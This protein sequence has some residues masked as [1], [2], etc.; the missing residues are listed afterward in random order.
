MRLPD[1]DDAIQKGSLPMNRRLKR[2]WLVLLA[3]LMCLGAAA[4]R[5]VQPEP[6]QPEPEKQPADSASVQV[7][8]GQNGR[9]GARAANGRTLIEPTWYYLR[10]MSDTVLIARSSDGKKDCFGLIRSNGEVLV[11]FIYS[12][13]APVSGLQDVWK[14]SFTE[15]GRQYYHLYHEDGTRWSD[16]AWES[17]SFEDGI[18]TAAFGKECFTGVLNDREIDWESWSSEYPVGLHRLTM[19]FSGGVLHRLPQISTLRQ[20]GECAAA[21]LRNLFVTHEP[22]DATLLSAE[23]NGSLRAAFRNRYANC[24]LRSAEIVRVHRRETD[25]LPSY[26]VQMHVTYERSG[27]GNGLEVIETSMMLTVSRNADGAYIYS[28]FTDARQ[29]AAA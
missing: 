8:P 5:W 17:C 14:A 29:S 28:G 22:P 21:Y 3:L 13:F 20:L 16:E 1:A 2:I 4:T 26:A 18:L 9:W 23:E 7:F 11:P 19:Q 12:A 27:Q 24:R 25:A 10:I 15:N 6:E